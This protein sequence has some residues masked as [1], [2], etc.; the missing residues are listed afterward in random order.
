VVERVQKFSPEILR[1][2]REAADPPISRE[3]LA[4][5]VGRGYFSIYRYEHGDIVPDLEVTTRLAAALGVTVDDLLEDMP[6]TAV[7]GAS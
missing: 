4:R 5:R 2:L 6:A 1:S 3:E 7:G